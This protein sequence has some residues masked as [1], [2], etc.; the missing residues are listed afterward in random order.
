MQGCGRRAGN[1]SSGGG[2]GNRG[3]CGGE[4]RGTG[5]GVRSGGGRAGDDLDSGGGLSLFHGGSSVG[6]TGEGRF[7][8][9]EGGFHGGHEGEEGGRVSGGLLGL[10]LLT[11]EFAAEAITKETAGVVAVDREAGGDE[12]EAAVAALAAA[13]AAGH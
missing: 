2:G 5:D 10:S 13:E 8:G 9:V 12:V 6:K 11:N 7:G 3:R 1:E 4:G